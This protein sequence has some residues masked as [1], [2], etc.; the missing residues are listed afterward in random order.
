M[1]KR[2]LFICTVCLP[3]SVWAQQSDT[4]SERVEL[5]PYGD[6]ECWT[7]RVIKE[8]ALLGGATK[9]VYHIGPTQTIEGA[10]PWVVERFSV[11]WFECMGQSYGDRQGECYRFSRGA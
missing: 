2:L 10:E 5:L 1:L 9:E 8:S 3:L 7:T 11:G 4:V 6:M